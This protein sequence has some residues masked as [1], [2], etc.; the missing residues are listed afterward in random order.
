MLSFLTQLD[1]NLFLLLN[2]LHA[3]WLDPLM[4]WISSRF[5]WIPLYIFILFL[6]IKNYGWKTVGILLSITV[7]IALSD[8]IS[9]MLKFGVARFRPTHT[10]GLKES[11]HTLHQYLGGPFGFVSSHAANAFALATYTSFFLSPY[12]KNYKK[13]A[14][15]WA[16]IVAYSRIYL[17]VHFPADVLGGALLGVIIAKVVY[18]LYIIFSSKCS[19][20]Y[21]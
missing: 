18:K 21:C 14:F 7:L 3:S 19:N 20:N 2:G 16:S 9:V 15:A 8:Q 6:L 4:W 5:I 17:G 13:Y 10:D 11:V 12:Y 1:Q